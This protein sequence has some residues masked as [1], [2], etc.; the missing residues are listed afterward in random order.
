VGTL[1]AVSFAAELFASTPMGLASDAL[2][3]RLLMTAGAL[4]GAIAV[5][6]FGISSSPPV[7]LVSRTLE[8]IG[9]AAIVPALLAYI[10]TVT[11]GRPA[12]RVRAMSY[13]ELTLLSGLALG[14]VP[15]GATL[16]A[17]CMAEPSLPCC[18]LTSR[19]RRSCF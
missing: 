4:L 19:A 9:A 2:Q 3:P 18:G 6:L 11:E 7:F 12:L 17:G 15:S 8:G 1:S 5:F 10:T 13:F 16:P 14:G